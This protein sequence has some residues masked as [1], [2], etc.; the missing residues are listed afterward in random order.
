MDFIDHEEGGQ[1]EEGGYHD[2]KDKLKKYKVNVFIDNKDTKGT[3]VISE[4]TLLT[5]C[6]AK[7]KKMS[8]M[9]CT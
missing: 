1:D 8:S 6:L 2:H 3:P 5:I 7:S 9:V 4:T